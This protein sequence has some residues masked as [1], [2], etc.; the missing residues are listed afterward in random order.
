MN[1]NRFGTFMMDSAYLKLPKNSS[2]VSAFRPRPSYY[3]IGSLANYSAFGYK[4]GNK[5]I[6]AYRQAGITQ[7]S[8]LPAGRHN[9]SLISSF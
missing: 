8:C 5:K 9:S 1:I 6:P 3:H 2:F 7:H 4:R